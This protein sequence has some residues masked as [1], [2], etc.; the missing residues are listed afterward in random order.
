MKH[1][2]YCDT[3]GNIGSVALL[4]LRLVVGAAFL[5]HGWPKIQSPFDWMGPTAD[6]PGALQC[7]AAVAEFGGGTLLVLG[8]L[9][10][11]GGARH[12]RRD[13][14]GAG[15]GTPAG[16]HVFVSTSGERS[17]ELAAV[18]LAC[19]LVLLVLGPGRASVDRCLFGKCCGTD[20][21]K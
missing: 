11:L 6:I 13:G 18:Y 4:L 2:L 3:V 19:A 16:Q 5:F 10:R 14:H 9:T 7:A 8:L 15:Q 17:F 1:L 20:A 12:R 21:P